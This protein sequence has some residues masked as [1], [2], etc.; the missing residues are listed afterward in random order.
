MTDNNLPAISNNGALQKIE[1]K[2]AITNKL[3]S[4]SETGWLVEFFLRHTDFFIEIIS[5]DYNLTS[6][7]LEKY[8]EKWNWDYLSLNEDLF[9]S[10]EL[11]EKFEEKWNWN[12]LSHNKALPWSNKLIRKYQDKWNWDNLS[13]NK[14]I[15]WSTDIIKEYQNK[16]NLFNLS[17]IKTLEFHPKLLTLI[18]KKSIGANIIQMI[19]VLVVQQVYLSISL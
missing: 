4:E 11:L 8:R 16:L 9:W 18:L 14:S 5:R 7:F 13:N 19:M 3:I 10:L 17:M 6:S 12:L 1:Q 15:S 2:L